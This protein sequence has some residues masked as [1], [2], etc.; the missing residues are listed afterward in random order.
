MVFNLAV[1]VSEERITPD[2]N[3]NQ[4]FKNFIHAIQF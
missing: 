3:R 2:E 4:G 1:I